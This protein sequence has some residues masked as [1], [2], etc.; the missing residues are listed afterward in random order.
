MTPQ[1]FFSKF[2]LGAVIEIRFDVLEEVI[3]QKIGGKSLML[4]I[5]HGYQHESVGAHLCLISVQSKRDWIDAVV[6]QV[7]QHKKL[8]KTV[9]RKF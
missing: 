3:F 5:L 8:T 2:I 1:F 7:A 6:I 9:W 4:S